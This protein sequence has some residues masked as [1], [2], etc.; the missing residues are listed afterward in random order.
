MKNQYIELVEKSQLRSDIP[1]FKAGDTI[2]VYYK[3][4]EGNKERIQLFQGVCIAFSG[5]GLTRSF[6]VRKISDGIGIERIIPLNSPMIDKLVVK[7][8]G[9]VRRAKLYYLR[10][11]SGKE[12]RIKE[13]RK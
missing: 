9:R 1:S 10:G 4:K 5:Q 2:Q 11:L 6:T 7:A 3:V 12:A 13:I 8:V